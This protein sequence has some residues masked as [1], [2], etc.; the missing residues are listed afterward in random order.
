[1]YKHKIGPRKRLGYGLM[2]LL[3]TRFRAE[4]DL[5]DDYYEERADWQSG[6]YNGSHLLYSLVRALYPE[7]VVEIGSARG[8]ST[9]CLSLACKDNQAGKV[10]AIDPH[11]SNAWSDVNTTG[12][13]ERFLRSR[14]K[15][16]D[17]EPYCEV[18]RATST[19]AAKTW[20]RPIDLIF[21]DGDHTFEGVKTDFEL[22]QPYFTDKALVIFHDTSWDRPTWEEIKRSYNRTE[23]LGVPEFMEYLRG[24]GYHS[25]TFPAVPGITV[26][27]PR[28]GGYDFVSNKGWLMSH[29]KV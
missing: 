19:E 11:M 5:F 26:L 20:D 18:I 21:I 8:K 9:C 6:L 1:M 24:S 2:R 10:F 22:F 23:E 27:D 13:N 28:A 25:I 4:T 15:A 29:S 7:V 17:L 12:D 14:L 16:Y 3:S